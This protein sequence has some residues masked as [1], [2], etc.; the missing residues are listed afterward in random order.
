MSTQRIAVGVSGS[1]SNL[2][3]LVAAADRGAVGGEV[4][5]VFA[6]RACPALDWAAEQGIETAL[7]PGG[8]D[9]TLAETLDGRRARRG[10]PG[11]LPAPG[12]AGGPGGV[13]GPDPQRPSLAAA[14][15][16]GPPRRARR[17]RRAAWR[18]PASPSTSS[19]R[20][21]TAARSSPRRPV[22]VLPGDDEATPARADPRRRAPAAAGGG[23]RPRCGR[24]R[25]RPGRRR[26]T[27]DPAAFDAHAPCRGARCSRSPT[28]PAWPSS[29][30]ASSPAGSSS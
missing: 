3:A 24:G 14:G 2:R 15:V 10:G 16:P 1:G 20:R 12:R 30:P 5:L 17:A 21:S 26:A 9:A 27:F 18:S 28:R 7:V 13:R 22:P 29:A 6:D 8:D 25:G 11:R 19:T 4:A 23:R